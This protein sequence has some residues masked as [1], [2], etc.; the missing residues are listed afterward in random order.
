M[1]LPHRS[2]DRLVTATA[3]RTAQILEA[4]SGLDD[5]A[6]LSPSALPGGA[7]S[8]LPAISGTGQR[9]CAA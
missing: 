4:L 3:R 1:A 8:P 5:E 6:L 7:D 9:L 2:R